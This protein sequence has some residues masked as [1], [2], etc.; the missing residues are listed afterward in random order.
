AAIVPSRTETQPPAR[1][2]SPRSTVSTVAPWKS[3]APMS[4]RLVNRFTCGANDIH[5]ALS[6]PLGGVVSVNPFKAD[7][8]IRT[9]V[10]RLE[11]ECGAALR[12][13]VRA[14]L[15]ASPAD[16]GSNLGGVVE[17]RAVGQITH[18]Y[19]LSVDELML[20]SLGVA[21]RLANPSISGF[22]VGAVGL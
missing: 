8:A 16:P 22:T 5:Y 20:L 4:P 11:Q 19:Q 17:A 15:A 13:A 21:Q 7:P 14:A 3:A 6:N 12:E 18:D 10:E 2:L 1:T 9:R